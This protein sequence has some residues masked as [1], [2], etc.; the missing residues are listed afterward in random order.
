MKES[1]EEG[2]RGRRNFDVSHA[3]AHALAEEAHRGDKNKRCRPRRSKE[4]EEE[5]NQVVHLGIYAS[6]AG[7]KFAERRKERFDPYGADDN[8]H[9]GLRADRRGIEE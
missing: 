7:R 3:L 5:I 2:E 4:R 9:L 1:Q 6:Q 8:W